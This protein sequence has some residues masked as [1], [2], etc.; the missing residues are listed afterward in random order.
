MFNSILHR[1]LAVTGALA[2]MAVTACAPAAA[3]ASAPAAPGG[4][5]APQ[6]NLEPYKIGVTYPLT[7][8][9]AAYTNE[10]MPAMQLAVEQINAKG[11]IKG[12]PLA[13]VVEDTKGSPEG[14]V[15]AYRKVVEVDKVQA[16]MTIFTNVV[17]AQI[18]LADQLKVPFL[19]PVE[20][21]GLVGR[22]QYSFAHSPNFGSTMPL[23]QAH[24]KALG[25]KRVFA[26]Y[27]DN[28]IGEIYSPIAKEG[29][30]AIGA[31]Y[32]EARYKLGETDYRGIV[33]RAKDY[34]PDVMLV[35]GQGTPDDGT[36]IKQLRESGITAPIH[37]GSNVFPIK[38]WA[39]A[40][41]VY[42]DGMVMAGMNIDDKDPVARQFGVD[43]KAKTGVVP[44]V[45]ATE[46]YDMMQMF[47]YAIDKGGYNGT[48]IRDQLKQIKGLPSVAGGTMTMGADN[49]SKPPVDLWRVKGKDLVRIKAGDK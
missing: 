19:S 46:L 18:P 20:S 24:W 22:G 28:A 23:L 25:I 29:S 11:G 33:A 21:P 10:I 6:A 15:A 27:P 42:A 30:K 2:L 16:V 47:I 3:P 34:K 41:G 39:D 1:G 36:L 9:L 12:H 48:A 26:F 7:G 35:N 38:A 31:E 32:D 14:G 44:P 43:F 37:V 17:T 8:P 40:V 49:H 4:Q 13:L 5:A 45:V